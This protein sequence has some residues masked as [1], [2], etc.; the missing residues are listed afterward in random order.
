MVIAIKHRWNDNSR[1]R[2]WVKQRDRAAEDLHTRAQL[3][4]ADILRD[5]FGHVLMIAK[6]QFEGLKSGNHM[7]IEWFEHSLKAK[8]DYT[9][10]ELYVVMVKLRARSYTLIRASES[11]IIAQLSPGKKVSASVS[12]ADLHQLMHK[13]SLAGG[14]MMARIKLYCDRLRRK[15]TSAAQA[16]AMTAKDPTDFATDVL[17][18]LPR[19]RRVNVPRRILK[20]K[21]M[22]SDDFSVGDDPNQADIS[23]DNVDDEAWND[24]LDTYKSDYVPKTRAPEYVVD[25]PTTDGDTWYAWEMERDLTNEFVSA[26]RDGQIDAAN[27]AGITDFVWIAVI[28]DKVDECCAWRD[29]LLISEIEDQLEDHADDDHACDIEGDGL[30]PP[31]HFNCR[32]TLAPATDNIPEKPDD[33]AKDFDDWLNS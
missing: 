18:A 21:L 10:N 6:A 2:T 4:M 29:G 30:N 14:Q 22:E 3:E 13:D 9:A 25:I 20:P 28:D 15:I 26:V 33:G 23:V 31:L 19:S 1:Y 17:A 12:R 24:M 7:A 32:C 5:T 8:F 27:E 16:Y 11:E